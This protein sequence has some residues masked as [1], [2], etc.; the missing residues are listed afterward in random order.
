MENP[1]LSDRMVRKMYHK[2]SK[3]L[4]T[5]KAEQLNRGDPKKKK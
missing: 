3:R 1:K 5:T 2:H 4:R